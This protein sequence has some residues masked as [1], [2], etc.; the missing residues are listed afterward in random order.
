MQQNILFLENMLQIFCLLLLPSG[1]RDLWTKSLHETFF[2]ISVD[3]IKIQVCLICQIHI[4]IVFKLFYVCRGWVEFVKV[5]FLLLYAHLVAK[6]HL[7]QSED[8]EDWK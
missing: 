1:S 6:F 5:D 4:I 7:F 8:L 2:L 3:H